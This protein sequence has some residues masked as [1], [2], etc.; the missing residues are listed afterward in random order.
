MNDRDNDYVV[1]KDPETGDLNVL[2]N[3]DAMALQRMA[4]SHR[5]FREIILELSQPLR[6]PSAV[7]RHLDLLK[8]VMAVVQKHRHRIAS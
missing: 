2:Y 8:E 4:L 7:S 1:L 6:T 5:L 3:T